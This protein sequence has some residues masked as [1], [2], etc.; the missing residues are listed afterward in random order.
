[1][2]KVFQIISLVGYGAKTIKEIFK[3]PE[4][5]DAFTEADKDSEIDKE[6]E[7]LQQQIEALKRLRK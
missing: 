4:K 6:L 2:L 7:K 3:K 1:M 5:K